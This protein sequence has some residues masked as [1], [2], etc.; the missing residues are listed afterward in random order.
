MAQNPVEKRKVKYDVR[1][2]HYN[3]LA[4]MPFVG[5]AFCAAS[6]SRNRKKL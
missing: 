3:V 4:V 2:F 1:D 5:L 6:L